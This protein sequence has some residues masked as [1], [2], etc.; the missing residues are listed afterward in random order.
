MNQG[1]VFV[2]QT[3]VDINLL[4]LAQ[5]LDHGKNVLLDL[6]LEP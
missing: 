6:E 4:K 3:Q 2:T 5:E 1:Q